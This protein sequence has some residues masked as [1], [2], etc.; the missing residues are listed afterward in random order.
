MGS[1][2]NEDRLRRPARIRSARVGELK[3][4]YVPDGVVKMVPRSLFPTTSDETWTQNSQFLDQSGWLTISA[5]GLLIEH[6]ERAMLIDAGY[7]PFTEQISMME[8]GMA[9]MYGGSF[10]D[11]LATLG[12][13]PREIEKI[14]ITHLHIEH[15]GW[16]AHPRPGET[17]P[18][19]THAAYLLSQREW[20][21]RETTFGITE[22]IANTLATQVHIVS[23]GDEVFPGV[24]CVALPGHTPGQIGFEVASGDEKLFAFADVLHSPV[25]VAHPEWP[26]VGESSDSES[27]TLRRRVLSQLADEKTIGFGIHFADVPFGRVRRAGDSFSWEPLA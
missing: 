16:A 13:S 14:G 25:Q 4:S 2:D 6:G 11:S 21:A 8:H 18:V 19:F 7:G 9:C 23:D 20:E 5:G 1:P 15:V 24:R 26:I 22:P 12:R 17:R 27:S 3:L 10:L